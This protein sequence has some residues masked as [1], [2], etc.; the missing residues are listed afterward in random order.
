MIGSGIA[1]GPSGEDWSAWSI[2]PILPVEG[3]EQGQPV[4]IS[5]H[6]RAVKYAL[7]NLQVATDQTFSNIVLDVETPSSSHE[8]S[9]IDVTIEH[10]WRVRGKN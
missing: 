5:W 9:N 8:V 7:F 10:F 2:I 1:H 4:T 3:S 6:D